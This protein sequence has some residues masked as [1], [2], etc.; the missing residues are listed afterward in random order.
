MG[1][2]MHSG[3]YYLRG[4]ASF[5]DLE[6][7][8]LAEIDQVALHRTF[9]EGDMLL[10]YGNE[11]H[12]VPIVVSGRISVYSVDARDANELYLYSINPDETCSLT[13]GCCIYRQPSQIKAVAETEVT[14]LLIPY[15][16]VGQWLSAYPNFRAFVYQNMSSRF[17]DLIH[18]IETLAFQNL[19]DRLLQFLGNKIKE[20]NSKLINMSHEQIAA[21][22]GTARVVVSRLLKKLEKQGKVLLFR[23]QIKV[24]VEL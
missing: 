4:M 9:A 22:L 13:L 3:L 23:N 5:T 24:M 17:M 1:A 11:I 14:A 19:P 21:D 20:Q 12:F 15:E 10:D 2:K 8:L 6:P 16:Y 7:A 18:I